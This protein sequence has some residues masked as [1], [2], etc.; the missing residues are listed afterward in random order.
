MP[1]HQ[2]PS[3]VAVYP[4]MRNPHS[5]LTR[6][7]VIMPRHP[8]IAIAVPAMIPA[9][10]HI[11]AAWR[12]PAMLINFVGRPLMNIHLRKRRRRHHGECKKNCQRN[13]FHDD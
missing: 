5:A 2:H 10:P 12:M 1:F 7:P 9:N 8:Y 3:A 11:S 6:R 4:V 13:L